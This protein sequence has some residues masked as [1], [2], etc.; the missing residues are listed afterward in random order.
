M[1]RVITTTSPKYVTSQSCLTITDNPYRQVQYHPTQANLLL[2]G[3]TDGLV[4]IY[5]TTISDED[6]AL[7][8]V[9]NHG[10]SISHASFLGG[11]DVVALSHDE[12][13]S[14]HRLADPDE[15]TEEPSPTI[16]GD[17][18]VKLECEYIVEVLQSSKGVLV[19]AGSH[20]YILPSPGGT[21]DNSNYEQSEHRL[22]LVPLNSG[23]QWSIDQESTW[24]ID[25]AHGDEIIRSVCID[26]TVYYHLNYNERE[27]R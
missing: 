18:R 10:S 25:G 26:D 4:N 13:L 14:V 3:S 2:S 20:G 23:Q 12:T 22:D 24:R 21:P 9:I 15:N 27:P 17:L 16:F 1:P 11:M 8:Q 6:D 5:D 19:A 7:Y